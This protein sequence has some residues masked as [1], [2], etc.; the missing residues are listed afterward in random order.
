M[1]P[2]AAE[3]STAAAAGDPDETPPLV[4]GSSTLGSKYLVDPDVQKML[5]VRGGDDAAFEELVEAYQGRVVG[6]LR[7]MTGRADYAEDLA[8]DVFLRV[9]RSRGSYEPTARFTTWLFRITQNVA[10]NRRRTL[11]RRKEVAMAAGGD[12]GRPTPADAAAEKSAEQPT[13]RAAAGEIQNVVR[14]AVDRLGE[15]QRMALLLHRFEG[16]SYNDVAEAMELSMPAVKSL[17]SRARESLRA[18]L[19]PYMS[20]GGR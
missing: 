7:H 8:Q 15:R 5:R 16:L 20:G 3:P 17:L 4:D 9:Y 18:E 10:F 13:R 2:T 19:E 11:S 6:L 1:P 12:D 14:E